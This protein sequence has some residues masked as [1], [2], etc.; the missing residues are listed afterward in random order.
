MNRIVIANLSS[1]KA[2]QQ[3][4]MAA[5]AGGLLALQLNRA[6]RLRLLA[7]A[8]FLQPWMKVLLNPQPLPPR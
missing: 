2:L 5:V 7:R 3:S 8:K 6:L 1:V 4:E